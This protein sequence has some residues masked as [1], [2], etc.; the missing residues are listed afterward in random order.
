MSAAR[1]F[2]GRGALIASPPLNPDRLSYSVNDLAKRLG[3]KSVSSFEI[4]NELF[5]THAYAGHQ[6]GAVKVVS[7][8]PK[9]R[10]QPLKDWLNEIIR[11]FD[12][13]ERDVLD[14]RRVILGLALVEPP[15]RQKLTIGGLG[16]AL[17]SEL[18]ER[19]GLHLSAEGTHL[20]RVAPPPPGTDVTGTVPTLDDAPAEL[21][22]LGRATLAE[23][24]ARRIRRVH[25]K[26][27]RR[28]FLVHIDGPWGSGKSSMLNLLAN[29]LG[30]DHLPE[31]DRW[32]VVDFNAWAHQRIDP[33]WWW[34][35]RTI[36]RSASRELWKFDRGAAAKLWLL[37]M[38]WRLRDGWA[39]YVLLPAAVVALF[40]LWRRGIFGE[41]LAGAGDAG[42]ALAAIAAF[43]AVVWGAIKALNRWLL[44]GPSGPASALLE[45][46]DP[47]RLVCRRFERVV[48]EIGRPVA[49]F[50]DDLDRCRNDY[51][52]SLL[53]GIQTLFVQEPVIYIV[54]ADGG[55]LRDAF[56]QAYKDFTGTASEPGRPLGALFL[57][58]TFQQSVPLPHIPVD[59]RQL[60]WKRLLTEQRTNGRQ[61]MPEDRR[62]AEALFER[63][64]K[65]AEI[66]AEL[67]KAEKDTT[68]DQHELR[69]AAALQL[70][71]LAVQVT[72]R[73]ALD[74]FAPLLEDN[75]RAMKKLVNAYGLQR[76]LQVIEGRNLAG[77]EHE[78][79]QLAL[80]TI[81]TIRW[82]ILAQYLAEHPAEVSWIGKTRPKD[83]TVP[84][85]LTQELERLFR[86]EAVHRVVEWRSGRHKV[87]L[88]EPAIRGFA[89]MDGAAEP[90]PTRRRA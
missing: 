25:L 84:D 22:E 45:Q 40:V 90:A 15:L 4:A 24:L 75:P 16:A 20:Y 58:K 42:K 14:G 33:P 76:D 10:K 70:G 11:V 62:R 46:R 27:E 87:V 53:E 9:A 36:Q 78:L 38:W 5:A 63:L 60:Y 39:A 61:Q 64:G 34:L 57:E 6:A 32:I 17:E 37:D 74:D 43:A 47:L 13:P 83:A 51:V 67:R 68:L 28:A 19:G 80:W 23:V 29:E 81:L 48:R 1:G 7:D 59:A 49:V 55:W 89:G 21:D 18:I 35:M 52:V 44:H 41:D 30:G 73:H 77:N 66:L 85:D 86:D 2:L 3:R 65:D 88:D 50:V 79:R 8:A 54:A 82:P 69:R 31:A 56:A 72:T 71:T 12:L 26:G